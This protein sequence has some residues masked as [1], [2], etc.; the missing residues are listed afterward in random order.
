[1]SI[2]PDQ[3]KS[4]SSTDRRTVNDLHRA[5]TGKVSNKWSSYLHYYDQL[6]SALKDDPLKLFEIG[7]QNGGSLETWGSYFRYAESI[8]GC[9]IDEKCRNLTFADPRISVIVGN[10]NTQEIFQTV[11]S[12][13]PFDVII[14]DGSHLSEDIMVGFLNYF[15]L[16]KPGG[17]YVVEDTHAVYQ[18]ASTNIHKKTTALA[19]FK[20]LTDVVNYEFWFRDEHIENML[21]PYMNVAV[22][23][24][25]MEGW[26]D[27]IE[28]RNS[29]ITIRKSLNPTHNKVGEII[30]AGDVADVDPAP[31][32]IK[33]AM[34]IQG[35][36][37]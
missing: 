8:I 12:K 10:A 28:F 18:R 26:I 2:N 1:M 5:K 14:D 21:K 36:S 33:Q 4:D 27:S 6:F 30:V 17:I 37:R 20:D 13:G 11:I 25:L 23:A 19:F 16:L 22:P 31:L 15:P 34:R 32:R 7:I 35:Q 3:A 29:I 9:D 24:F